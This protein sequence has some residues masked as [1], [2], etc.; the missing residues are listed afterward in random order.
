MN[1]TYEKTIKSLYRYNL[2]RFERTLSFDHWCKCYRCGKILNL[3]DSESYKRY[4]GYKCTLICFCQDCVADFFD[5]SEEDI[6]NGRIVSM[7]LMRRTLNIL[8]SLDTPY[9][10]H[11]FIKIWC[12]YS[13]NHP[14]ENIVDRYK[15]ILIM[16]LRLFSMGNLAPLGYDWSLYLTLYN[17]YDR[18]KKWV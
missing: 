7:P 13:N 2:T 6:E 15:H 5:I 8:K 11:E 10:E 17:D 1:E 12:K 18:W 9:N 3:S 4:H 14:E 16:Y